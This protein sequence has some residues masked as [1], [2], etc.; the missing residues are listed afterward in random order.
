MSA[1]KGGGS[2]AEPVKPRPWCPARPATQLQSSGLCK[3]ESRP[4]GGGGRH[5]QPLKN[6]PV[7]ASEDQL[8]S[9][10]LFPRCVVPPPPTPRPRPPVPRPVRWPRPAADTA[11]GAAADG[12]S[13]RAAGTGR[14]SS[15]RTLAGRAQ[16]VVAPER[17]PA[18]TGA[19]TA[20]ALR[21]ETRRRRPQAS[22]R[23]HAQLR[24][25]EEGA[26]VRTR[27]SLLKASR[28][29]GPS[30][31]PAQPPWGLLGPRGREGAAAPDPQCRIR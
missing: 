30:T 29:Q 19:P 17:G 1:E 11:P 22:S 27:V 26:G 24:A 2:E 12:R 23:C 6:V 18:P 14:P 4:P 8:S 10:S 25:R 7:P 9:P 5:E 20:P 15:S 21:L 13:L 31:L 16:D 28:S 3:T